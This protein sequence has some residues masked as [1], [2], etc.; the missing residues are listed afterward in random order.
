MYLRHDRDDDIGERKRRA[1]T[2][3]DCLQ[4]TTTKNL[5]ELPTRTTTRESTVESPWSQ[6]PRESISAP[7][8]GIV[9][10]LDE[11]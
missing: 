3:V 9:D 2:V 11:L 7:Q 6:G 1:A 8:Q 4:Q 10:E 5:H